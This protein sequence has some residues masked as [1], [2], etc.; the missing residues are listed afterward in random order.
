MA[1]KIRNDSTGAW[2]LVYEPSCSNVCFWYVPERLR[3]F[4]W[5][6]SSES[7]RKK[8]HKVAPLIK[9]EMQNQGDA[10]IGFQAVNGR[11]N[12][13]RIVFAS[14]DNV[15]HNDIESVM[16]RIACIGEAQWNKH[17]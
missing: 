8:I 15:T 7:Q 1:S 9:N 13:F 4:S 6:N 2:V 5:E 3:P 11:P 17:M 14:C 10:L 16:D 12:F